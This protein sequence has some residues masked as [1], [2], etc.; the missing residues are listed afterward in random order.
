MSE[1]EMSN[2]P[3]RGALVDSTDESDPQP[4]SRRALLTSLFALV[5]AAAVIL[6]PP[7]AQARWAN[8]FGI[9]IPILPYSGGR[10]SRRSA[11]RPA[12]VR[13]GRTAP[14]NTTRVARP[15]GGGESDGAGKLGKADY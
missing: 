2:V 10:R 3:D 13:R 15:S 1:H 4:L 12:T 5:S 6:E 7:P 14:K 9:P 8:F 11:G